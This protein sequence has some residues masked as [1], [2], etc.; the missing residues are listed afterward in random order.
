QKSASSAVIL[1]G[2]LSLP[3]GTNL[4]IDSGAR[5]KAVNNATAYDKT[6]N[7]CGV[8]DQSGKGC[9]ALITVSDATISGI[10]GKGVIDGQGGVPLEDNKTCWWLLAAMA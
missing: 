2:P 8:L 9:N 1:S 7:S 6:K 3:S 5:L 4:W 10:Y